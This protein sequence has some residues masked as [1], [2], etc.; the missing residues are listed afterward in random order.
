MS[1]TGF[2]SATLAEIRLMLDWAAAEGWNPGL[3]DAD[4]F[5]AAD[6][7]GFFVATRGADPVAAISVVNH[8]PGLAFLGLYIC[9]PEMRGQGVGLGLWR[10]ALAHAQGRVVGLD[11]VPAQQANYARSGFVRFGETRRMQGRVAAVAR[12]APVAGPGDFEALARLDRA[13]NG[14]DRRAFLRAWTAPGATRKTVL[15]RDRAGVAGFATARICRQGGKIGPV[16]APDPAAAVA[17][18]EQAAAAI[19]RTGV[20]VDVPQAAGAFAD[21]LRGAGFVETFTTARMYRGT[22]PMAGPGLQAIATMELG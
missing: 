19:G 10:H 5:H 20:S 22:P 1:G 11:G 17:L 3:D 7:A 4:A 15:L 18:V 12:T 2:R 8:S 13:A 16:V 9:R 21:L 6:P 14:H